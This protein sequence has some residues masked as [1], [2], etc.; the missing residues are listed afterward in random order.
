MLVV[1]VGV[2][3]GDALERLGPKVETFTARRPGWMKNVDGA[4]QFE[5]SYGAPPS[6]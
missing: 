5:M 4:Q 3:D 1:K 2:L 6:K